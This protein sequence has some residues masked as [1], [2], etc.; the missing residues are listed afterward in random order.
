MPKPHY[1]GDGNMSVRQLE[2]LCKEYEE[3]LHQSSLISGDP[4]TDEQFENDLL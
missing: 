4:R 2:S 1:K 3:Y